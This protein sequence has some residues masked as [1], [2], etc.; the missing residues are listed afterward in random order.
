VGAGWNRRGHY[1]TWLRGLARRAALPRLRSGLNPPPR[2][3]RAAAEGWPT[4]E[5]P[6]SEV[7]SP[8]TRAADEV[9]SLAFGCFR[10]G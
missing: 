5:S 8:R 6:V 2:Q 9:R 4:D 10:Q 7:V 1:S 3:S